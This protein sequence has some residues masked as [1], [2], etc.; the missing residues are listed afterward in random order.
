MKENEKIIALDSLRG[1]A[2]LMVCLFHFTNDTT[3][4]PTNN[5]FHVVGQH[6]WS[7][8]QLFF[9]I[10]GFVIPYSLYKANY[11]YQNCTFSA[12]RFL[13]RRFVRIEIPYFVS[14]L[15]VLFVGY[16]YAIS[17]YY[18]GIGFEIDFEN[19]FL[20]LFYINSFFDKPFLSS[21]YWTLAIEFQFYIVLLFIFPLLLKRGI[22][23]I[24]ILSSWYGLSFIFTDVHLI[25]G[26]IPYFGLGILLFR[27]YIK[28]ENQYY[29]Y[30]TA[31][32][33]L[34]VCFF[35]SKIS[36]F[37]VLIAS[38]II[39]LKPTFSF[40]GSAFLASISYSLY[41]I[42]LPIGGRMISLTALFTQNVYFKMIAVLIVLL[43][44]ILGSFIYY[45]LIEKPS[46]NL[47]KKINYKQKKE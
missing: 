20:H 30:C 40:W 38:L 4:L 32:F 11:S 13:A 26:Y 37:V 6:G 9:L 46:L 12:P 39:Y 33:L 18:K 47:A 14:I 16:L 23:F 36:F 25:F 41:L 43:I 27:N 44:C 5:F 15:L 7:G 29:F 31:T 24:L 1:I 22:Y 17:P 35:E 3:F 42:H 45:L 28:I 19:V 21:V 34:S 10:S 2:A 8:V